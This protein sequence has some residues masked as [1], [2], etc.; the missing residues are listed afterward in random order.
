MKS[1]VKAQLAALDKPPYTS[2]VTEDEGTFKQEL[3][4]SKPEIAYHISDKDK[5]RKD[6]ISTRVVV[7]QPTLS[8]KTPSAPLRPPDFDEVFNPDGTPKSEEGDPLAYPLHLVDDPEPVD[9]DGVNS[10]AES[11]LEESLL[12]LP[13]EYTDSDNDSEMAEERTIATI[14]FKGLANDDAEQWMKHFENYCAYK[15][16]DDPKKLALCN[17]YVLLCIIMCLLLLSVL[18]FMYCCQIDSVSI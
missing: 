14:Q 11:E 2:V 12:P 6:L 13:F 5:L 1:V 17:L 7:Q 16:Y 15:N 3:R 4:S 8:Q 18:S 10:E 9:I